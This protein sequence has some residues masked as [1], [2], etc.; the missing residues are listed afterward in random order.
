MQRRS[1]ANTKELTEIRGSLVFLPG[2]PTIRHSKRQSGRDDAPRG[3][4]RKTEEV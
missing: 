3:R 1:E 4:A 2:I